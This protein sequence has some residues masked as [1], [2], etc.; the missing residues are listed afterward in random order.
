MVLKVVRVTGAAFASPWTKYYCAPFF[1]HTHYWC[2]VRMFKYKILVLILLY[3]FKDT[4][5]SSD[6]C[7]YKNIKSQVYTVQ[8]HPLFVKTL[9][10]LYYCCTGDLFPPDLC[11]YNKCK[12]FSVHGTISSFVFQN[13]IIT[14][15]VLKILEF[16]VSSKLFT[17][18]VIREW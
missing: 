14:T 11:L 18:M 9:S 12:E 2:K 3:C 17:G 13:I 15:A 10:R 16:R 1:S 7:L 6:L 5:S 8:N 4:F